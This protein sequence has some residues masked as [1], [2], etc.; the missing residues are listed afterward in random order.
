LQRD[1]YRTDRNSYIIYLLVGKILCMTDAYV[2]AQLA[3]FNVRDI[4]PEELKRKRRVMEE[5]SEAGDDTP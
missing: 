2:D 1:L 3:D 5:E 4:T